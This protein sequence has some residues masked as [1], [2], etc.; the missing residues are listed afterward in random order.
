MKDVFGSLYGVIIDG[1][2]FIDSL[3]EEFRM[4]CLFGGK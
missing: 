3:C 1:T 4:F 2:D